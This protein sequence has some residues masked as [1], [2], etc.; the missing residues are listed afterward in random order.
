MKFVETAVASPVARLTLVASERGLAAV[1]WENDD[2]NRVR[3]GPRREN[4]TDRTLVETARQLEAYFAGRLKRFEL[5]LDFHGTPFQKSVWEAL[6]T[7]PFGETRSYAD[8]ARQVGRPTAFRAVGAA[9][10]KNPISIIAPCHRVIGSGGDLTGF[11]GGLAAKRMLLGIER[12]ESEA[13]SVF[14]FG[15]AVAA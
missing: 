5:P 12:Q 14:A 8:I 1:L 3:L 7:I 4:R 15:E 10:G 11:A 13:Q 2:P 9:N 6:L